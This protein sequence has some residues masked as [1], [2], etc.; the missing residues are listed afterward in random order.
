MVDI[1]IHLF[2]QFITEII[3]IAD[4]VISYF[5]QGYDVHVIDVKKVCKVTKV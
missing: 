2:S 5:L 3:S 1:A 4:Q